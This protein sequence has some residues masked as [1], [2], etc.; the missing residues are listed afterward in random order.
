VQAK[1]LK[2]LETRTG[3]RVGGTREFPVDVRFVAA[4]NRDLWALVEQGR[5]REDLLYRLDVVQLRL[6]PLRERPD[7]LWAIAHEITA[8]I[9]QSRSQPLVLRPDAI[10]ELMKFDWP[11]NVRQLRNTLQRAALV[12]NGVVEAASVRAALGETSR[13]APAL[14]LKGSERDH[15]VRVLAMTGYNVRRA[16]GLLKISRSTLYEKLRRYDIDADAGREEH[17]PVAPSRSGGR[18]A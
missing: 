16:A 8:E 14:A 6:P 18:I 11:G 17:R 7:Q 9:S 12:S 3:R 2:A 1:L 10:Q 5:F 4:T 13:E 15:I